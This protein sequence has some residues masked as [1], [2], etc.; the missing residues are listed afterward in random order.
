MARLLLLGCTSGRDRTLSLP[1]PVPSAV[2]VS[3][4]AAVTASRGGR[5]SNGAQVP[6]AQ[7]VAVSLRGG[8]G[9]GRDRGRV[10]P[11]PRVGVWINRDPPL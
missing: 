10:I 5:I 3:E 11:S 8:P 9:R 1:Q 4:A 2:P 7:P 6:A